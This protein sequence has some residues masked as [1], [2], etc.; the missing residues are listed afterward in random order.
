MKGGLQLNYH[1]S[2]ENQPIM[3]LNELLGNNSLKVLVSHKIIIKNGSHHEQLYSMHAKLI[4]TD[5]RN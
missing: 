5:W 2:L 3:K 4:K 1:H